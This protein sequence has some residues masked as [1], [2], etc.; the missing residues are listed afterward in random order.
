MLL[1]PPTIATRAARY[2]FMP[3][4]LGLVN[5]NPSIDRPYSPLAFPSSYE[6]EA[7]LCLGAYIASGRIW[8]AWSG[9]LYLSHSGE[10]RPRPPLPVIIKIASADPAYARPSPSLPRTDWAEIDHNSWSEAELYRTCLAPLQGG[11]VPSWL[12]LYDGR[13]VLRS[14]SRGTGSGSWGWDVRCRL[15]VAVMENVGAEM[16]LQELKEYVLLFQHPVL[17]IL[18]RSQASLDC[19][20][21]IATCADPSHHPQ[22]LS[23]YQAL[24]ARGVIHGDV[25]VRHIRLLR[26]RG[27]VVLLDFGE[28]SRVSRSES[29]A[30]PP[31]GVG[32]SDGQ[33]VIAE[34]DREV[35]D[36]LVSVERVA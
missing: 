9:T 20:Q 12:G 4:E 27:R 33:D 3:C 29:G 28:A 21:E 8:D 26:D 35:R 18:P 11:V 34:E 17:F 19:A 24:H 5:Q 7:R 22:I 36:L 25:A 31:S 15:R 16:S 23:A 6:S 13:G 1:V 2:P 10:G 32:E 14:L 30:P